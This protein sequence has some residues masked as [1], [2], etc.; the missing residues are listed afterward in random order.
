MKS[1]CFIELYR[2]KKKKAIWEINMGR[3]IQKKLASKEHI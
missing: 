2:K 1:I 3:T